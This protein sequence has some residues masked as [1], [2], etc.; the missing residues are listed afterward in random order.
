MFFCI[1]KRE[2]GIP[3]IPRDE[4][5]TIRFCGVK[6]FRLKFKIYSGMG[7]VEIFYG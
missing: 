7:I 6:Q 5:P 2:I 3:F 1:F 4:V